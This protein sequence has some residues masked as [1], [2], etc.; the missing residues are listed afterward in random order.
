MA[1]VEGDAASVE[2]R[3]KSEMAGDLDAA[4]SYLDLLREH[5]CPACRL[6]EMV[7]RVSIDG[8]A[9]VKNHK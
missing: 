3:Q 4:A 9:G 6:I 7:E 5:L 8:G 1:A 2:A